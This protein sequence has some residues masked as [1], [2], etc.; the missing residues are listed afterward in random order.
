MW[1]KTSQKVPRWQVLDGLPSPCGVTDLHFPSGLTR[2]TAPSRPPRATGHMSS[3]D[4]G[5]MCKP[6][7]VVDLVLLVD[8]ECPH[9]FHWWLWIWTHAVN[10]LQPGQRFDEKIKALTLPRFRVWVPP[11][12]PR[13]NCTRRFTMVEM[14]GSILT[15][16]SSEGTKPS[17]HRGYK[18]DNS[19]PELNKFTPSY[20]CCLELQMPLK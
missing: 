10:T 3:G 6:G 5:R 1:M 20:K 4:G 13:D 15:I 7:F 18:T 17:R 9:S 8:L 19:Y 11:E 12:L 14:N 2:N 16:C